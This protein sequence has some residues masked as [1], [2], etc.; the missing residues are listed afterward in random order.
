MIDEE[1]GRVSRLNKK[2][3]PNFPNANYLGIIAKNDL[4]E[5]KKLT[6]ENFFLIG[7]EL[8]ELGIN[9][10]CAPVLDL[11]IKNSNEVIGNR[12][13]SR[14]PKI[15]SLLGYEACNGLM[16]GKVNPVIK[17][18][19][20]HGRAKEDSHKYLPKI[21]LPY[22]KLKEDFFPFQKLNNIKYAMTAHIK[23]SKLDASNC[24]TQ[25]KVIIE[26]IIRKK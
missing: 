18:I 14:N 8:N 2:T 17:H 9:F 6:F 20:G 10:N 22:S 23:Y 25:S 21:D 16:K 11:L 3:W 13:F 4:E 5:C 26:K 19:P 1:G 24:A 15:V 7:K 12:S